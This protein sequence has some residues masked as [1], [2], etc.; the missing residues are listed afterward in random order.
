MINLKSAQSAHKTAKMN[1]TSKNNRAEENPQF[2]FFKAPISNTIPYKHITLYDAFKTIEGGYLKNQTI[3]L[4]TRLDKVDNRSFK[5]ISFPYATFSGTFS[6]RNNSSLL[7]HSGLIAIDFDHLENPVV[8]KNLLLKDSYFETELLFTSPNGNGLKWI[9]KIDIGHYS[10]TE[11]FKAISNYI[12]STYSIGIDTS[13]KDVSRATFLCY[14][15][16][17]FIHP[18]YLIYHEKVQS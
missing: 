7:Q 4:R 18:K 10:H 6:A 16:D 11:N 5:S 12:K 2:S 3:Q 17:V 1:D 14:D 9:I 8:I 15:P 13:C